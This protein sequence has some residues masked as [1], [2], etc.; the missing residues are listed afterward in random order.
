MYDFHASESDELTVKK[1]DFVMILNKENKD[2]WLVCT[3]D[4]KQQG[5]VPANYLNFASNKN[6]GLGIFNQTFSDEVFYS[7]SKEQEQVFY[8]TC[9]VLK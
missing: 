6:Q 3:T 8:I 1:G 7:S 5:L 4:S 9:F 2:W